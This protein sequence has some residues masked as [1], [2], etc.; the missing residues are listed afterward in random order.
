MQQN[1]PSRKRVTKIGDGTFAAVI[2]AYML[3]P[4]FLSYKPSTRENWSRQLWLAE[5]PEILGA[6]SVYQIRSSL[7]QSFL[8]GLAEFPGKQM[9]ALTA[10]RKVERWALVR[11]FLP[12]P[13]TTGCEVEGSDGGHIPWS[14]EQVALVEA[15][16]PEHISRAITLAANTGQRGSDLVRMCWTDLEDYK[17]QSG[18]NVPQMGQVKTGRRQ[19]VPLAQPLIAAMATWERR[20]GPLLLRPSGL[21]WTRERLTEAWSRERDANEVF[22]PLRAIMVHGKPRPLVLHGLRGTACVR[23]HRAGCTTLQIADMVGM[24]AIMVS[25]YLRF[26]IQQDNA[27]AAV[28]QL[29]RTGREPTKIM[30]LKDRS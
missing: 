14:D 21:P 10:L 16:A 7:V 6:Y 25:R 13:I 23:L 2:R 30:R 28:L 26:S 8:D 4:K 27:L 29:D 19:W 24:S 15:N 9:V 5:R 3:S 11:D 20:P 22:A 18:I 17:G 12:Y 1:E